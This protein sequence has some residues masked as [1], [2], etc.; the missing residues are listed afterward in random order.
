VLESGF[1]R[2]GSFRGAPI[3]VHWSAPLGALFF[4]GFQF[5]PGAWAGFLVLIL[6]HEMGHAFLA[7]RYRL[8]VQGIDIHGLG[9]QCRYEGGGTR[10][11]HI[12]IAWGGVLAQGVVLLLALTVL[13]PLSTTPFTRELAE[14]LVGT[15]VWLIALNLLPIPP[16]DGA[17]AWQIFGA[18]RDG[19]SRPQRVNPAPP[20]NDWFARTRAASARK[21]VA[22]ELRALRLVDGEETSLPPADEA[23]I[24]RLFERVSGGDPKSK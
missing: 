21:G 13:R 5:A 1:A 9:G 2:L 16:L 3:R 24:R 22:R 18:R 20:R 23:Q 6:I 19:P 8:R 15:N 7:M 12:V 4:C 10:R 14:T 17:T 11:Q